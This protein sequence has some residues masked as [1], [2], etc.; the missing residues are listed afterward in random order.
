MIDYD[1]LDYETILKL[2][3][4]TNHYFVPL[5]LGVHLEAWEFLETRLQ[6]WIGGKKNN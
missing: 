5:G 2:K 1:H 4:K 6:R 3:D